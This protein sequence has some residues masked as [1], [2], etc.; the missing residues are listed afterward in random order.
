MCFMIQSVMLVVL[1]TSICSLRVKYLP[2]AISAR[3]S[4]NFICS[5]LQILERL[6][7]SLNSSLYCSEIRATMLLTCWWKSSTACGSTCRWRKFRIYIFSCGQ[8]IN[9]QWRNIF[10]S[11]CLARRQWKW[12]SGWYQHLDPSENT[13]T[14][15]N[16]LLIVNQHSNQ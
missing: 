6:S 16:N 1:L 13:S 11:L 15:V 10:Y 12:R 2:D 9:T 3:I 4:W 8:F 5:W 14:C 7:S